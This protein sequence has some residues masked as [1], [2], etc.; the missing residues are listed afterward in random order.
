MLQEYNLPIEHCAGKDSIIATLSS[1]TVD[2]NE[3]SLDIMLSILHLKLVVLPKFPVEL[4]KSFE[5][6]RRDQV[7][8]S[9]LST[10]LMDINSPMDT[11]HTFY[12]IHHGVLFFWHFST[13][14]QWLVSIT[15][16]HKFTLIVSVH[17][18]YR[19]VGT[20]KNTTFKTFKS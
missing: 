17:E 13:S 18:Q 5:T 10:I 6:L 9:R 14:E 19:H 8:N 11:L 16:V 1:D 15:S 12:K 7:T 20:R 3:V 2:R 4:I